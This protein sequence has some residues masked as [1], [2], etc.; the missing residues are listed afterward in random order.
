MTDAELTA[1]VAQIRGETGTP[2]PYATA[3]ACAWPLVE[4]ARLTV[5]PGMNGWQAA[6]CNW[7]SQGETTAVGMTNHRRWIEA[8]TASRAICLAYLQAKGVAIPRFAL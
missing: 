4:E 1:L 2:D 6:Q 7:S 3:I 5:T 8:K